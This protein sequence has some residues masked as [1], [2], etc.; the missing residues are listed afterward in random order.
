MTERVGWCN[1]R[2]R[3]E[4]QKTSVRAWSTSQRKGNYD[5]TAHGSKRGNRRNIR[6]ECSRGNK[7]HTSQSRTSIEKHFRVITKVNE[8]NP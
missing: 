3:T 5:L 4:I 2:N 7:N 8:N 1:R 6:H